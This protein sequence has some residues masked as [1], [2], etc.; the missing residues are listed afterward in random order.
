M[1]LFTEYMV[2]RRKG[3]RE[4]LMIGAMV[5]AALF[6]MWIIFLNIRLLKNF[7]L[8]LEVGV[9]YALFYGIGLLSV[10][11]EY[12]LTNGELDIDKITARKRRMRVITVHSRTFDYFAPLTEPHLSAYNDSAIAH[13][14]DVTDNT[15]GGVYFAVF[16]KGSKK[17]C[18]TFQPSRG[19]LEDLARTVPKRAYFA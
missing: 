17:M 3:L 4:Y 10:E 2:R 19:M 8:L 11:Y 15:G 1:D 18:I 6:L 13:R 9:V 7:A 12:S 5:I 16:F 14:I